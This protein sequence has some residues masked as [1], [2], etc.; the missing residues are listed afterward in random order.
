[1]VASYIKDEEADFYSLVSNIL[2]LRS[3]WQY[4]KTK[5]IIKNN[6]SHAYLY[7]FYTVLHAPH[8]S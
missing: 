4:D 2:R 7:N 5:H 6:N 1:M 3:P 8:L